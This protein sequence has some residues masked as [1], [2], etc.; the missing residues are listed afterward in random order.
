MTNP[1]GPWATAINAGQN[2]QLS[3]FWRQR[4]TM[5]VPTSQTSPVL[6]R[7]TLMLL[8]VSAVLL[9]VM[10]TLQ[11]APAIAT[12]DN[13]PAETKGTADEKRDGRAD[14]AAAAGNDSATPKNALVVWNPVAEMGP[15][16]PTTGLPQP[17]LL[18]IIN[19]VE[20]QKE[21]NLTDNQKLKAKYAQLSTRLGRKADPREYQSA[22]YGKNLAE[23]AKAVVDMLSPAQVARL[24]QIGLRMKGTLALTT[25]A[26]VA[27]LGITDRQRKALQ[28]LETKFKESS[29]GPSKRLHAL[30]DDKKLS[31]AER[32]SQT[33]PLN[34]DLAKLGK[35]WSD[36]ALS[37]LTPQQ[38]EKFESMK[39]AKIG[40]SY[41]SVPQ[42]DRQWMG[43]L[44]RLPAVRD[45]IKLTKA[46]NEKLEEVWKKMR[47]PEAVTPLEREKTIDEGTKLIDGILSPE[48]TA[49]LKQITLQWQLLVSPA[50]RILTMPAPVAALEIG[51][52]QRKKLEELVDRPNPKLV[53]LTKEINSPAEHRRK[54]LQLRKE[55]AEPAL[56]L[57]TSE[58]RKKLNA[59]RGRDFDWSHGM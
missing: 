36:A 16:E 51:E 45:D 39:G 50:A 2:P 54:L 43:L 12:E 21:L 31:P 9:G 27:A 34:N 20:E 10:P 32:Q 14:K 11:S 52:E 59:L 25:P 47:T 18:T 3:A 5:L 26:V 58:Q 40:S 19:S 17:F 42:I 41:H 15:E 46:Q 57:L 48:Q 24:K 35:R 8:G 44:Q 55:E 53:A 7:R 23:A 49:R 29:A 1:Y 56:R 37:V 22:E 13:S 33:A 28:D 4:L 6:S 30:R 38:R